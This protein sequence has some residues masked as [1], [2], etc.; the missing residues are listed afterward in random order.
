MESVLFVDTR[1]GPKDLST[2]AGSSLFHGV[3]VK[4][5]LMVLSSMG[6]LTEH[7]LPKDVQVCIVRNLHSNI[8]FPA[9]IDLELLL[10]CTQRKVILLHTGTSRV[11]LPVNAT[12]FLLS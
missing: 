5:S 8:C 12:Y 3:R 11:P 9:P 4:C 1:K 2:H 6:Y 10:Q 7:Y